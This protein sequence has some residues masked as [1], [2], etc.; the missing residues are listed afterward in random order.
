MAPDLAVALTPTRHWS[1]RFGTPRNHR[2]WGGFFLTFSAAEKRVW[3]VGDSGYDPESCREIVQR[4][5]S[6]D[7]A[8]VPIG[9]YEPR[10]F[11][12]PVHM[13][14][15]EAVA[16]HRLVGA[17]RSAAM[18]WGMFQLSDESREAPVQALTAA[19]REAGVPED[20]FCILAPGGSLV[21]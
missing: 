10:W 5:G 2:L 4:C 7:L 16:T 21:V 14:P 12:A 1:K 20:E 6:P 19:R 9:A 17:R 15:T 8:L 18:H 13:N 11:M 3:F